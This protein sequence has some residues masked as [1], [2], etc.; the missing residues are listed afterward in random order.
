MMSLANTIQ[1]IY[2][3]NPVAI[4]MYDYFG[5]EFEEI[6]EGWKVE[7]I[8]SKEDALSELRIYR[9]NL[10]LFSDWTQLP[11]TPL[12]DDKKNEWKLYRQALRD[13]PENVDVANWSAP[14]WPDAP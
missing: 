12:P 10:L 2:S 8:V 3:I 13:Y 14:P 4:Q 9:N 1:L 11:D 6:P 5:N 7:T